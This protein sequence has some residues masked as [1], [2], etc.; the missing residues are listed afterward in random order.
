ML[1]CAVQVKIAHRIIGPDEYDD[2][3]R[4]W[5]QSCPLVMLGDFRSGRQLLADAAADSA[6]TL[7]SLA[8][9]PSGC[10][11]MDNI[12][13]HLELLLA[14]LELAPKSQ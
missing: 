14:R 10:A 3:V 13:D 9:S 7:A 6:E 12:A 2:A 8:S 4:R 11:A 5:P 1:G